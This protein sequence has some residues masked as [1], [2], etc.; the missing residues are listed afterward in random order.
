[1]LVPEPVEI[2]MLPSKPDADKPLPI[3]KA[4]Q[5]PTLTVPVFTN[6]SPNTLAVPVFLVNTATL[7]ELVA[8]PTLDELVMELPKAIL[9]LPPS[10]VT[11]PPLVLPYP[12][13]R[14]KL[15]P[16]LVA[17]NP[18]MIDSSPPAAPNKLPA[19]T[20]NTPPMLI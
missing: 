8:V 14:V 11:A 9:P 5:L 20:L 6:R 13:A 18:E 12:K 2:A 19:F 4:P 15:P 7:P 3:P 16:L 1:M 10:I 17:D